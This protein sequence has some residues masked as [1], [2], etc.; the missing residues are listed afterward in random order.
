MLFFHS[1]EEHLA[2]LHIEINTKKNLGDSA[3]D[4]RAC[5]VCVRVC[6]CVGQIKGES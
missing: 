1:R 6:V 2:R 5:D 4:R 3:P